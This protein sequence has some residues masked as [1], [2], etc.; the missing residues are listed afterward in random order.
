MKNSDLVEL[1]TLGDQWATK[2]HAAGYK[3]AT[4][5]YDEVQEGKLEEMSA[6]L[7][8]QSKLLTLIER[9]Q[10][11]K[12]SPPPTEAP[13][14]IKS[15]PAAGYA[16]GGTIRH[17]ESYGAPQTFQMPRPWMQVP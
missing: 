7:A 16:P 8:F 17:G 4:G 12:D 6:R 1:Q 10:E 2:A 13:G 5:T 9:D 15:V 3:Y 11:G 14:G